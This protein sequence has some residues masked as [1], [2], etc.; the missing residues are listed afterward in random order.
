MS[1]LTVMKGVKFTDKRLMQWLQE[2]GAVVVQTKR[3]EFRCKVRVMDD[4]DGQYV[5]FTSASGKRIYNLQCFT[6]M[7]IEIARVTGQT[8]FDTGCMVQD[9]FDLTRRTLRAS[10]KEYD[11]T[12]NTEHLIEEKEKRTEMPDGTVLVTPG[13]YYK[14]PLKARFWFYDLPDSPEMYDD[15]RAMMASYHRNFP[16]FTGVP[17]TEVIRVEWGDSLVSAVAQ[18][19]EIFQ[20]M[21]AQGH[22][23]AMV[24]RLEYKYKVG[25]STDWMK[26]KPEEEVDVKINGFTEGED[27]FAGLVGSLL[28]E[29]EDG[30]TVSFSGFTLELR[31]ELTAN[32]ESYRGRWAEVKFMQR[33]S[34][35]GYRHPRFYRWHPD[36]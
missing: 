23:G 1:S 22:E 35:G 30:S 9:S 8:V 2:D 16:E 12:G 36:K 27:G 15:R 32:F 6:A 29:A 10:K 28:G 7:W 13:F 20:A 4:G 17:E 25:R 31:H 34:Q 11:L 18:V 24:K 3:D 33:D 26:M 14:G 5:T 19:N 21:L